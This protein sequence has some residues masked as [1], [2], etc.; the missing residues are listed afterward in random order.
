MAVDTIF[1]F[2]CN[3]IHIQTSDNDPEVTSPTFNVLVKHVMVANSYS[4]IITMMQ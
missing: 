1:R 4:D 3:N 2:F